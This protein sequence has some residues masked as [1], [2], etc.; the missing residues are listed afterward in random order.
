MDPKEPGGKGVDWIDLAQEKNKCVWCGV[1]CVKNR[2]PWNASNFTLVL[3]FLRQGEK[4][5]LKL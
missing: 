4:F 1:V 2:I 3:H 5:F